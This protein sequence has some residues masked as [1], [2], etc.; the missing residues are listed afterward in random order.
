MTLWMDASAYN[1]YLLFVAAYG[2]QNSKS[3]IKS[4]YI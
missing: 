2:E 3:L 1:L 4:I